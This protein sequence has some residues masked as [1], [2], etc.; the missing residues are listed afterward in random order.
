[1]SANVAVGGSVSRALVLG[2]LNRLA[3]FLW[4]AGSLAALGLA[5]TFGI[6]VK[7]FESRAVPVE[8]RVTK[9]DIVRPAPVTSADKARDASSIK[10]AETTAAPRP[11]TAGSE[12]KEVAADPKPEYVATIVYTTPAGQKASVTRKSNSGDA[13]KFDGKIP[14]LVDPSNPTEPRVEGFDNPW[15]MIVILGIFAPFSAVAAW[16]AWPKTVPRIQDNWQDEKLFDYHPLNEGT[17]EGY[18]DGPKAQSAGIAA[19]AVSIRE[20]KYP[21]A[22]C[23]FTAYMSALVYES[24]ANIGTYLREQFPAITDYRFFDNKDTQGI[25]FLFEGTAFVVLRGTES[26]ADWMQNLKARTTKDPRQFIPLGATWTAPPRHYGFAEAWDLIRDQVDAW[27]AVRPHLQRPDLPFV[28][29]GHSLGGALAFLGAFEFAMKQRN[30]QGVITF[31]APMVGRGEWCK[32]YEAAN[33]EGRTLRLVF[34]QDVV[35]LVLNMIG[36]RHV[37]RE[38]LPP[39]PPLVYSKVLIRAAIL[40]SVVG[41]IQWVLIAG[42]KNWMDR[43]KGPLLQKSI[44]MLTYAGPFALFAL[45]AHNMQ[46]R[47]SLAL[48]TMS[49]QRIRQLAAPNQTEAEYADCYQKLSRHLEIIRGSNPE[50]PGFYLTKIKNLPNRIATPVDLAWFQK[51]Y[52]K[53]MF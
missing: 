40:G 24:D 9:I 11:V 3:T 12:K 27:I 4:G 10:A 18:L 29:T 14:L 17:L 26:R 42:K 25:G 41:L 53:R 46:R 23:E 6:S 43:W 1:M 28:F 19:T 21:L 8:G 20:G 44:L 5:G 32:R 49:Y 37:G 52:P 48:S 2:F 51:W 13:F 33:L 50:Q 35:P 16:W 22:L 30:V 38:W 47:Y 34:D 15:I 31:G 36:Y 7:D 39:K 45:A